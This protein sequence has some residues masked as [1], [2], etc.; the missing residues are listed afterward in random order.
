[1]MKIT[2]KLG[3][4]VPVITNAASGIIGFDARN[5]LKEVSLC[6]FILMFLSK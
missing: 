2:E 6:V 3:S 4:K 1:M 5:V